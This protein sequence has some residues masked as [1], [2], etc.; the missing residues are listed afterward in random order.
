[1]KVVTTRS[2]HHSTLPIL[3]YCRFRGKGVKCFWQETGSVQQRTK[4]SKCTT[5]MQLSHRCSGLSSH[6]S[7]RAYRYIYIIYLYS[8]QTR[9]ST[10]DVYRP[11]RGHKVNFLYSCSRVYVDTFIIYVR[12]VYDSK[13]F[14]PLSAG[15]TH[16]IHDTR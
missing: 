6:W 10:L 5:T 1:M 11:T 7:P 4:R 15:R 2:R 16:I 3:K 13:I 14:C 9:L 12:W 8:A